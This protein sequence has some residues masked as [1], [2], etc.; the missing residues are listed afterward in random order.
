MTRDIIQ[1]VKDY[2][3]LKTHGRAADFSPLE[4][5]AIVEEGGDIYGAATLA[6]LAGYVVGYKRAKRER[7]RRASGEKHT[8]TT[9][10]GHH[11]K[12]SGSGREMAETDPLQAVEAVKKP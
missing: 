9:R 1:A 5:Q 8:K 2:K 3:A 7:K 6:L 12:R 10:T 4:V 11:L